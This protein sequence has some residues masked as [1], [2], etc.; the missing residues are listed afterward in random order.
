M[1]K[2]SVKDEI[3]RRSRTTMSSAFL[4]SANLT[5]RRANSSAPIRVSLVKLSFLDVTQDVVWNQ[6][7]DWQIVGNPVSNFSGRQIEPSPNDRV[8]DL[9]RQIRAAQDRKLDQAIQF[10]ELIP[11][12]QSFQMIFADQEK[13]TVARKL[14]VVGPGGVDRIRGGFTVNFQGIDR[15]GRLAAD[16]QPDHR[17]TIRGRCAG[18][19]DLERRLSGW[20]EDNAIERQVFQ[21]LPGQYQVSV[22]DRV[23]RSPI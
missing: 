7:R 20:N 18:V 2:K 5:Q 8:L 15:K 17:K 10:L 16:R 1:T 6:I 22:M 23:E 3:P 14:S 9:Q 13:K 21:G 19:I 4:S 12:W 11:F